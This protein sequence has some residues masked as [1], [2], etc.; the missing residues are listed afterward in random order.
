MVIML[1]AAA[2]AA[3][4]SVATACGGGGSS[5]PNP[6]ATTAPIVG[7]SITT[8]GN[9]VLVIPNRTPPAASSNRRVP[10]FVS[11]STVSVG[12]SVNG[13][14]A[15]YSDVSVNSPL[16]T[17]G[18]NGRVCTVPFTA[19][20]G[21]D[22][23]SVKLYDGAAGAGTLLGTGT[24]T[25][26]AAAGASFS[27]T[28]PV[29]PIASY[30]SNVAIVWSGTNYFAV[31]TPN[32]FTAT[33]TFL[34][35]DG[36]TILP[37]TSPSLSSPLTIT[38][39]DAHVTVTPTTLTSPSQTVTATYDGSPALGQLVTIA[40]DAGTRELTD[41]ST[42]PEFNYVVSTLAGTGQSGAG[43]GPGTSATF[44]SPYGLAVDATGNVYVADTGNE[45][46]RKI[47]PAGVVSTFA[48]SGGTGAADG[49]AATATF[50][51]PFGVAVSSSGIV[52]VA[53]NAN[54]KIRAITQ[55]GVVSTFAGTGAVGSTDGPAATATFNG[56]RGIITDASGNVYV[57][58]IGNSNGYKI[59]MISAA[60]VVSTIAGT[61][62]QGAMNG[63]AAG[64]TFYGP[65]SVTLDRNGNLYI[66]DTENNLIREISG[67]IVS[68]FA[69]T[70]AT[71][72]VVN[73]PGA[74]ATFF[75]P[76]GT[77]ID[78]TGDILVADASNNLI[79]L[80]TS[81]GYVSTVAGNGA[82]AETNGTGTGAAFNGPIGVAIDGSGNIYVADL[83]GNTIR[84]IVP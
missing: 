46:I 83:Q 81:S 29:N 14:A 66:A 61:G 45:K 6:V 3:L 9:A 49:A 48:G 57:S 33:F 39:N 17:A 32:S 53:D 44:N 74:S 47:T 16:C 78:N 15:V 40:V 13:A 2:F 20:V 84:K 59:R 56:P 35:P 19:P 36:N 79:R 41:I 71:T 34:D 69:G 43:D 1:R 12:I 58:D 50:N 37:A 18:S 80:I 8:H 51:T 60:G 82:A 25:A 42:A 5:G 68:T 28:I 54:N 23:V 76:D 63:P 27:V 11:P 67:G 4:G 10:K 26:T 30:V 55:A 7:S 75:H 22:T 73:G 70:G 52:Y 24:A 64:A 72:P 38:S 31:G 65:S 77:A 21:S 62:A